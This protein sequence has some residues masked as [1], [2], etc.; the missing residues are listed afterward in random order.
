MCGRFKL[1]VPFREIV[2]LYN[3]TNSVNLPAR[4]N[5]A[6]T[7]DVLAVLGGAERNQ[8]R[9]EM[10]R[11]GLVPFWAKDTKIGYG[12]INA[13]AETVAERPAVREAFKKRRCII[14][15]DGF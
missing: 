13:K 9:G 8:R 5:I 3:L 2:R 11:W 6:P 12:L 14:P 4:Y 15:A 7:Q 1:T 10:M